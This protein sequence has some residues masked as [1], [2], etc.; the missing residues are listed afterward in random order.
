M[1]GVV[2]CVGS[3]SSIGLEICPTVER[4]KNVIKNS[5]IVIPFFYE[6]RTEHN[7]SG[8]ASMEFHCCVI[9]FVSVISAVLAIWHGGDGLLCVLDDESQGL[10]RLA[11][12]FP[13]I[14][15]MIHLLHSASFEDWLATPSNGT[16]KLRSRRCHNN[17][18]LRRCRIRHPSCRCRNRH[19]ST[20]RDRHR[21]SHHRRSHCLH[22]HRRV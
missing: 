2:L 12:Q 9:H 4:D 10:D 8:F 6:C 17:H 1:R 19:P 7:S 15:S 13:L 11:F 18:N 16:T 14:L 21:R 5:N 22:R 3:F 20:H